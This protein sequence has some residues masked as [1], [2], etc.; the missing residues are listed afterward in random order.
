MVSGPQNCLACKGDMEF[1]G[2]APFRT[3][4]HSGVA[5]FLF[6]ELSEVSE[7]LMRFDLYRCRSCARIEFYDLDFSIRKG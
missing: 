7:K 2:Q 5:V 3:G 6:G 1:L 4:G